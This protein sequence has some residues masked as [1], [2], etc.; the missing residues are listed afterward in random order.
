MFSLFCSY[1]LEPNNNIDNPGPNCKATSIEKVF[2]HFSQPLLLFS[3]RK[4]YICK[5]IIHILTFMCIH[6]K[7]HIY[8]CTRGPVHGIRALGGGQVPQQGLHPLAVGEPLGDVQL[9]ATVRH[10]WRCHG[11]QKGSHRCCRASHPGA[12]LLAER[13]PCTGRLLPGGQ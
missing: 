7:I 12:R 9:M 13:R 10:P 2:R 1:G 5:Y 3:L 6:V 4:R 11:G 8:T